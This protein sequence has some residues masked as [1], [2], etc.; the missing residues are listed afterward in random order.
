[1]GSD[2]YCLSYWQLIKLCDI[3]TLSFI[4]ISKTLHSNP[5]SDGNLQTTNIAA[6]ILKKKTLENE[7]AG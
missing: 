6:F 5:F 7:W 4:K 1:M 2:K 3:Y